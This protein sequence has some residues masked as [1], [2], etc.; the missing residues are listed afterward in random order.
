[1]KIMGLGR[2]ISGV[3][4]MHQSRFAGGEEKDDL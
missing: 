1:M 2:S 3:E 4:R